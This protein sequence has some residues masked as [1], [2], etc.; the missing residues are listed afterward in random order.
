[1]MEYSVVTLPWNKLI[2]LI[3]IVQV[4]DSLIKIII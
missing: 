3:L 2:I 4:S 1:M